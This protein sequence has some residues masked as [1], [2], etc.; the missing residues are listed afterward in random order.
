MEGEGDGIII[1][2]SWVSLTSQCLAAVLQLL[3]APGHPPAHVPVW[4]TLVRTGEVGIGAKLF[5][6]MVGVVTAPL[7]EVMDPRYQTF[8]TIVIITNFIPTRYHTFSALLVF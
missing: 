8:G 7:A 2:S 5:A 6:V 4:D 3:P 1:S